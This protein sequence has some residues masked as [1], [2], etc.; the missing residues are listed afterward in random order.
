[1]FS[2]GQ[3][4]PIS[5]VAIF[6]LCLGGYVVGEGKACYM[7]YQSP[8]G[9]HQSR[10]ISRHRPPRKGHAIIIQL[11]L[12]SRFGRCRED[13]PYRAGRARCAVRTSEA[14]RQMSAD[15][16]SALLRSLFRVRR[17]PNAWANWSSREDVFRTNR[18]FPK[19]MWACS[20]SVSQGKEGSR[21]I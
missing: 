1:M 12:G 7:A 11:L 17:S 15:R 19:A 3:T 2:H 14:L 9:R 21:A 6:Y 13:A 5:M 4:R 10:V 18:T 20:L 16:F 8:W